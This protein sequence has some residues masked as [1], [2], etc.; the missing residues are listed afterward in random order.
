[1][2]NVANPIPPPSAIITNPNTGLIDQYWYDYLQG[3]SNTV[4]SGV[5]NALTYPGVDPTGATDSTAGLQ[6]A[7]NAAA[8]AHKYLYVPSGTYKL[9]STSTQSGGGLGSG[10]ITACLISPRIAQLEGPTTLPFGG[11]IIGDGP[12]F[13]IFSATSA[14]ADVIAVRNIVWGRFEGFTVTRPTQATN[15]YGINAQAEPTGT[16]FNAHICDKCLFRNLHLMNHG[17]G[18]IIGGSAATAGFNFF[19]NIISE[20]NKFYGFQMCGEVQMLNCYAALNVSHGFYA[21]PNVNSQFSCGQ[22]RGLST[23]QNGGYGFICSSFAGSV[24]GGISA[25]RL[26]DSFFGDDVLGVMFIDSYGLAAHTFTN[27]FMECVNVTT[28]ALTDKNPSVYFDNCYMTTSGAANPSALVSN[29]GQFNGTQHMLQ[30]RGGYYAVGSGTG[31]AIQMPATNIVA[32]IVGAE[33]VNF[34]TGVSLDFSG[35]YRSVTAM[36]CRIPNGANIGTASAD[37]GAF[38]LF[39]NTSY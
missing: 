4:G 8:A 16:T 31:H 26:S 2:P 21:L 18:I 28:C 32:S 9:A 34:G 13:T 38:Y 15:G 19:E 24:A 23:F 6:A 5:V 39:G 33:L 12:G 37:P 30:V 7:W 22:W 35:T 10:S 29:V 11:G 25:I 36:G 14:T 27:V 1:M 3:L 17:T 20:F